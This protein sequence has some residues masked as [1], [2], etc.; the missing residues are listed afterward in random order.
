MDRI[1]FANCGAGG[2]EGAMKLARKY[3]VS[4]SAY[5]I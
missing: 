1:F 5:E 3:G 4:K 2:N